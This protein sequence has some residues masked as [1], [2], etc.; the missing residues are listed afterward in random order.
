MDKQINGDHSSAPNITNPGPS[1][2]PKEATNSIYSTGDEF[3]ECRSHLDTKHVT[4]IDLNQKAEIGEPMLR[5]L[6]HNKL[7]LTPNIHTSYEILWAS[8][9]FNSTYTKIGRIGISMTPASE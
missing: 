8:A 5:S 6:M 2:I 3:T 1:A 7:L 9:H 4:G